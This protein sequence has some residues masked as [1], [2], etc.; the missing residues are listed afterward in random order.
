[1]N[2][3]LTQIT[4]DPELPPV[5]EPPIPIGWADIVVPMRTMHRSWPLAKD[6]RTDPTWSPKVLLIDVALPLA[7]L[8]WGLYAS[9]AT[10]TTFSWND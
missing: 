9:I 8:G 1:M 10:F 7:V 2:K 5:N 6:F 3:D 4:A